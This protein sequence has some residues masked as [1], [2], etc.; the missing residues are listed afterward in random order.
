[1]V[2]E[3]VLDTMDIMAIES[4]MNT[5][6]AI[7]ETTDIMVIEAIVTV[8]MAILDT[9]DMIVFWK[10]MYITVMADFSYT[11]NPEPKFPKNFDPDPHY[12]ASTPVNLAASFR[13][14]TTCRMSVLVLF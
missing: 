12:A 3:T 13:S 8:I 6:K 10:I 9:A 14:G 2:I 1:M 11:L 4:I 7:I 5:I